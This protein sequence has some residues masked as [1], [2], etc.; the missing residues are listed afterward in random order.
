MKHRNSHFAVGYWSRIRHGRA[1]PDQADIDPRAL[2][3]LLPFVF[4]LDARVGDTFVYRLAGTTLCERYGGG[5]RGRDFLA[6][7]GS[8]SRVRVAGLLR[9]ALNEG[10]P[11][12]LTSIG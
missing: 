4:L 3:R 8:G 5:L 2:K 9:Y 6:H 12:C 10:S 11:A 7:W 1:T